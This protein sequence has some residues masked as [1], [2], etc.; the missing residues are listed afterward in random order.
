MLIVT[1]PAPEQPGLALRNRVA[2]F[3]GFLRAS[4]FGVGGGDSARVLETAL[5]VGI[6]DRE[7]LRWSL[8]ALLCGRGEEWRRF[9]ALFDA[10]FRPANRRAFAETHAVAA[11]PPQAAALGDADLAPPSASVTPEAPGQDAGHAVRHG[12]SREESLASSDFRDLD[13]ADEVR[14]I[15]KL[16]RRFALRLKHLQLRREARVEHGRRL[17]LQGTIRR[18]VASGGT[19]FRLAWKDRRRVRPRL[20]L[21]LDVSRSMSQ[22]SFFYLRLA[23]ALC[24]ELAD[25]HC[26]IFHTRITSV[27]EALHDPDPWRAQERLHLLAAGW[28]GGTRIGEC[29][30]DFNRQHGSR[31]VHSR[32]GVIIVS[33]GYDTGEPDVLGT[34]LSALRRRARRILWINPLLGRPDFRPESRGMQAA[35]PHLDLLAPGA[36]LTS[37]E[38]ILPKLLETLR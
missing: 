38:R 31:L 17:D 20:V 15:E 13:R 18:S 22:Y 21:L 10:Y 16:M 25:V 37:I 30:Q 27:G 35:L 19:P 4:G 28:A 5:R 36:D 32:T 2:G 12:A 24:A 34:A 3:A 8:K 23:R 14:D 33:D 26:F 6:M 1:P 7:I 9:D 11:D 29:L